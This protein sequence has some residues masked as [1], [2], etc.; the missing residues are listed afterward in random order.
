MRARPRSAIAALLIA[1]IA[2]VWSREPGVS[3]QSVSS[4]NGTRISIAA[5]S[6]GEAAQWSALIDGRVVPPRVG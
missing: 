6:A 5:T 1:V 2:S 3:A 4:G